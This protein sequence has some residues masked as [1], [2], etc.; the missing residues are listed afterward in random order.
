MN[1]NIIDITKMLDMKPTINKKGEKVFVVSTDKEEGLQLSCYDE[2]YSNLSFE[3]MCNSCYE[4]SK[5]PMYKLAG[6]GVF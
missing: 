5:C 4:K 6:K 2:D 3:K 1:E